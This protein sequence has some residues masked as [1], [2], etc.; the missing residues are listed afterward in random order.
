MRAKRALTSGGFSAL[1]RFY[2]LCASTKTAMVLRLYLTSLLKKLK[3]RFSSHVVVVV[4]VFV[5]NCGALLSA[6]ILTS[7]LLFFMQTYPLK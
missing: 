5:K 6:L 7:Q 2:L 1:A 4:F 3:Q